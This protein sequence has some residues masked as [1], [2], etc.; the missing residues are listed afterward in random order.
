[1]E[2]SRFSFKFVGSFSIR[3]DKVNEPKVSS[4]TESPRWLRYKDGTVNPKNIKKRCFQYAFALT[5]HHK[6]IKNLSERSM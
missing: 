3:H 1:M 6:E 4:Y 5:Q 2:G